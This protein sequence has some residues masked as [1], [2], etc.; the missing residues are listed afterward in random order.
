MYLK[1][2][3]EN[4]QFIDFFGYQE[5]KLTSIY[6]CILMFPSR[7]ESNSTNDSTKV[8]AVLLKKYGLVHVSIQTEK[9]IK[10]YDCGLHIHLECFMK[11][12]INYILKSL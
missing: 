11:I 2:T 9:K 8:V 12:P 1:T 3:N 7:S 4:M 5:T 6:K 10:E